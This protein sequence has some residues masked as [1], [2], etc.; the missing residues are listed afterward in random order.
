[1]VFFVDS[2]HHRLQDLLPAL[3]SLSGMLVTHPAVKVWWAP[4]TR[5]FAS[6]QL[7]APILAPLNAERVSPL[8]AI[9]ATVHS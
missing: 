5:T 3:S 6:V 2:G 4:G 9:P 7:K 1:M 8:Q